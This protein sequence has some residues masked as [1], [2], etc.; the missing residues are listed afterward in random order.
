[1]D[2]LIEGSSYGVVDVLKVTSRVRLVT[3]ICMN[4]HVAMCFY[5]TAYI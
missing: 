4:E 5:I 3:Y 2:K 1:M